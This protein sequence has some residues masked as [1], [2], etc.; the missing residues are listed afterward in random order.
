MMLINEGI[1]VINAV[2]FFFF[3]NEDQGIHEWNM[4][5]AMLAL[6]LLN[7]IV[8]I[9]AI[10]ITQLITFI[11]FLIRAIKSLIAYLEKKQAERDNQ[12]TYRSTFAAI[13]IVDKTNANTTLNRLNDPDKG[14]SHYFEGYNLSANERSKNQ[15]KGQ[16]RI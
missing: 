16:I 11:R 2:F 7:I 5:Y 14:I 3:L 12:A 4:G 9:L 8:N 15:F 10:I 1:L 6:L 13:D